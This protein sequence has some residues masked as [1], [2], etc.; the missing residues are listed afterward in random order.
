MSD[1]DPIDFLIQA[2]RTN[3]AAFV[4]AVHRPRFKHSAFSAAVCRA[5]D[6]FVE[7]MIAGKCPI[8]M[9]TCAPQHGKSSLISRCVG[10][11][12]AGRL[13]PIIG[14]VRVANATY[15]ATL[16]KRN[17]RDAKSIMGEPIYRA[18]F[19]EMSLVGFKGRDMADEFDMPHGGGFRGVGV[20]GGLTGFSL[21]LATI[22]DATKDAQEA[23]S[24]VVQDGLEAWYESVVMTRLQAISGTIIIGTPWS[25]NDILA[26]IRRKM[27][28][29]PRFTRLSFPALNYPDQIGYDPEMPEGPLVPHLH[30]EEKLR[31]MKKHMSEFWW[32][33]MYQQVPLAEF[34]AIFK[35]ANV[36]YYRRSELPSVFA[37]EI[38]TVDATFK[39]GDASDYVAAGVWGKT[40]DPGMAR[41]W[42]KDFRRAK[43]AFMATAQAIAELRKKHPRVSR[44][45]IE[46][47]ANGAALIDML[48]KHF[49][50][51]EGVPPMGSKEARAHAVSWVWE[52][53]CVMLPHPDEAPG[54]LQWVQEITSFPDTTTGHDDTVDCMTLALQQLCV[55]DT[56][57][58]LIN[59]EILAKMR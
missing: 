8:L 13:Q 46:E 21:N 36:Q 18:I 20:G 32:S 27:D 26:R 25:A 29:D 22:D 54:I 34:G 40:Q 48:K 35:R 38:I 52:G 59:Q 28:G 45:Y 56:I 9:L 5:V 16:A 14:A 2:A 1:I 53:N 6:V 31:E 37:R 50:G 41:V 4:S 33:A 43:L 47:A 10:P 49:T 51:I 12:I 42:L 7:D 19:P 39:D 3:F 58:S 44:T 15:A 24:A 30:S 55:R 17:L 11:Y 57:A 23:L